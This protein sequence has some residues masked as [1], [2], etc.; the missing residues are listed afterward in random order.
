MIAAMLLAAAQADSPA[1]PLQ[2]DC[3]YDLDAMLALDQN[4]FD[5]DMNGG[6]RPLGQIDGCE[7]AT[8]ELIRAWR[9]EKRNHA[10]ILY[11]HEGQM[12]AY[13]GQTKEAIA[14]FGRTYAAPEHDGNFGWNYY[15]S[16]TIA[17]LNGD[18]EGLTRAIEGLSTIPEPEDNSF[19][20]PDGT[21]FEMSW[22]PN[23]NVLRGFE[24]CWGKPYKEAY[25]SGCTKPLVM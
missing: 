15:V 3:S 19:T 4:S 22:P 14:L 21:V 6:W 11:W 18:R 24:E 20:R 25:G 16:G 23:M 13:A 12:R 5:Q 2:P 10:S 17:F 9:H 7:E 1:E 8:A